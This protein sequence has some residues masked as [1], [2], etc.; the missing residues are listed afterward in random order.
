LIP[1]AHLQFDLILLMGGPQSV[2][3]P[4]AQDFFK[5]FLNLVRSVFARKKGKMIGICLGSQ[6][7]AEALGG[8]V[9]PGKNGPEIGF[10]S[11]K[12]VDSGHWIF[13]KL[14]DKTEITAF[15]LHE[16]SFELPGSARLLLS[17]EKYENQ[18]FVIDNRIFGFQT[19]LEPTYEMI[20]TWKKVH[21]E[22]ISRAFP[23]DDSEWKSKQK[24]MEDSARQ[25][26]RSIL[27]KEV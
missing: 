11:V 17:S 19:H 6:I 20:E 3:D 10:S 21:S 8:K 23:L 9:F 4:A 18:A 24:E 25:I 22:F 15:H 14:A 7:I 16:D 26:F 12:I 13:E 1:E 5:P 27:E 2:A